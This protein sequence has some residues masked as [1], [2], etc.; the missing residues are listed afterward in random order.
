MT[1]KN[2]HASLV[3]TVHHSIPGK[4]IFGEIEGGGGRRL[5]LKCIKLKLAKVQGGNTIFRGGGGRNVPP[6]KTLIYAVHS[7]LG[8]C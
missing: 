6:K 8:C 4:P 5:Q 2:Q 1:Y 3:Y 7:N